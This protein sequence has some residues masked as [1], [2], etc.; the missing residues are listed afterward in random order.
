MQNSTP[1]FPLT[2][3]SHPIPPFPPNAARGPGADY[4]PAGTSGKRPL[5]VC[6]FRKKHAKMHTKRTQNLKQ[7]ARN[8]RAVINCIAA[9]LTH[10]D[11]SDNIILYFVTGH[12]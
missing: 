7:Q 5:L 10:Y 6:K 1:S 8:K 11:K 2:S 9:S 4:P 3:L 12:G